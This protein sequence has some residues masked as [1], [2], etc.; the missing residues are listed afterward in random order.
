MQGMVSIIMPSY[1]T[2]RFIQKSIESVLAQSYQNWELLIV[3]DCSTD[4]TDEVVKPFLADPRIF[5]I[6]NEKNSGAAVSRNRAL[7]EAKGKWIA[8]LDSDDLWHPLKLEK[9]LSFMKET[10]YKFTYTDYQIQLNGEWL[11]FI[12]YGPQKVTKRKMKDYCYFSTIT[13]MYDR[14]YVGLIQI[15]PVRKNNDYAMWLKIIEK[16]PCYRLGE[17]LS[18]YIKHEGSISSGSKWKLIKHHYILWRVAEH[19]NPVSAIVLT[20]RNLFWGV[21]KKIKYKKKSEGDVPD[22]A[23]SKDY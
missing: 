17:S 11:P 4:N 9:Q 12:Y 19:K 5:Y 23:L 21:V 6:K 16:T 18:Y 20:A 10:G 2:G 3:D 14:E 15:E 13:V 7:R 22:V 1:N 8:F